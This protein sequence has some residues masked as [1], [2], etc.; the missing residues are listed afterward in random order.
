MKEISSIPKS[1]P[2]LGPDSVI[3]FKI[4]VPE[5]GAVKENDGVLYIGGDIIPYIGGYTLE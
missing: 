3:K 4:A 1:F 2:G 5:A